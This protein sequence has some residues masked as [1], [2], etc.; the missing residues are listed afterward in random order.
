[1]LRFCAAVAACLL[2]LTAISMEADRR[3][4]V[5]AQADGKP[6]VFA[7]T[8][9]EYEAVT[10]VL[11]LQEGQTLRAVLASSNAANHFD[12]Y[13]PDAAKPFYVGAEAG[14][15][16][17]LKVRSSGNY[18]IRVFLLRFAARDGQDARYELELTVSP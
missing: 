16:H 7:D 1:M 5:T 15:S 11:P 9:V 12:I 14:N 2:P 10:Y 17:T 3:V 13:A 6:Q 4:A 18:I 8:I